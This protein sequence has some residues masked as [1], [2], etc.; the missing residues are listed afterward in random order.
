[1]CERQ[2]LRV[3][4]D[5]SFVL[6]CD[7]LIDGRYRLGFANEVEVK[8]GWQTLGDTCVIKLP[9]RG[10]LVSKGENSEALEQFSFEERF[11]TG[12]AVAVSL[13][14]DG[15]NELEF[16]G[17]IREIKP[18]IPFELHCEDELYQLK[19]Q[20]AISRVFN[21]GLKGLLKEVFP[22]AQLS[23]GIPDVVLRN[24]VMDKATPAVVLDKLKEAYGLCA[25]FIPGSKVLF[26]GLPYSEFAQYTPKLYDF[27]RNVIG[28][29]LEYRKT[30]DVRIKVRAVS[31]LKNNE[32]IEVEVGD[33]EGETRTLHTYD[34]PDVGKLRVWA[35][36]QLER[37]KYEGY[38]GELT[39][40]GLPRVRHS[41]AVRLRDAR[42]QERAGQVYVVDK[43]ATT[44]GMGG[45]RRRVSLGKRV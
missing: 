24:F 9:S 15:G 30:E 18:K 7:I 4:F 31:I 36:S 23:D 13:G 5:M 41:D 37:L 11:K 29:G 22:A 26:V 8:S 2:T 35:E 42:Y 10:V 28:D 20:A 1:M 44:W 19:R 40:F 12:M 43:V 17:Y 21:G 34:E 45:Y 38:A 16:L 6:S 3:G 33:P 39:A 32:K 14:Y 25:Y 27:Q